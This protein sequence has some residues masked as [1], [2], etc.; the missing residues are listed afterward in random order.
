MNKRVK[1]LFFISGIVISFFVL[2]EN[3]VLKKQKRVPSQKVLKEQ[4]CDEFGTLLELFPAIMRQMADLQ[5]IAIKTIRG[6]WDGDKQ[7]LCVCATK[8]QLESCTKR[9]AALDKQMHQ[10]KKNLEKEVLFL[11][12][13]QSKP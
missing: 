5:E 9:L 13:I 1:S 2:A 8:D 10:L 11:Q 3:F 12:S 7:S 6:Y 4:C